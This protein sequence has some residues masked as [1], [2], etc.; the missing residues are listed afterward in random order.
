MCTLQP[1]KSGRLDALV[2]PRVYGLDMFHCSYLCKR[3]TVGGR[4]VWQKKRLFSIFQLVYVEDMSLCNT[5]LKAR[6]QSPL[7]GGEGKELVTQ[8]GAN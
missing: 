7:E 6:V 8:L 5:F 4:N 2:C 1:L 3:T